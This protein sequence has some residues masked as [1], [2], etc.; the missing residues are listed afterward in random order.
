MRRPSTSLN[1]LNAGTIVDSLKEISGGRVLDV[2][3][4]DGDFISLLKKTLGDYDSFI[5]IDVSGKEIDAAKN[6]VGE[7]ASS[8]R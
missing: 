7:A 1:D 5:G 4:G 3:T 6:N 8:S 2:A